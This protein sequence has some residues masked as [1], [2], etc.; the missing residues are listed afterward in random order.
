MIKFRVKSW[1]TEETSLGLFGYL[2]RLILVLNRKR[3]NPNK[4][5]RRR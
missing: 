1:N 5:D 4:P 3:I 2:N